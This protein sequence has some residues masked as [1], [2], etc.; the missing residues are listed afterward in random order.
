MFTFKPRR[1]TDKKSSEQKE[2]EQEL[3]RRDV[4]RLK[5]RHREEDGKGVFLAGN[6]FFRADF[7]SDEINDNMTLICQASWDSE[8]SLIITVDEAKKM[9]KHMQECI[10]KIEKS[11]AY[12]RKQSSGKRVFN[13]QTTKL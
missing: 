8:S 2:Y 7:D 13:E 5:F 12:P 10:T 9:I 1:S 4:E 3:L 11:K 6:Y